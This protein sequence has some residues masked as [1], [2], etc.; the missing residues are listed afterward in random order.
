MLRF[1]ARSNTKYPD[2]ELH[3]DHAS[4]SDDQ[5]L[6]SPKPFDS[7]ERDR[8]GENV[9]QSRDQ[10]DQER[11]ADCSEA[12]EEDVAEIEDEV[13]A[14]QLLHHLHQYPYFERESA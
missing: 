13:D 9:D 10:G 3:Y 2:N 1:T 11:I 6:A 8:G 14:S 4:T 7:P 12:F 5:D